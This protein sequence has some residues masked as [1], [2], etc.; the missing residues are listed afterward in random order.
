[1]TT[2]PN[3]KPWG[4]EKSA[5]KK[6][7][8]RKEKKGGGGGG[9]GGGER[10][11]WARRTERV[12]N[13]CPS[14][15]VPVA[16]FV[17]CVCAHAALPLVSPCAADTEAAAAAAEAQETVA[18]GG[19]VWVGSKGAESSEAEQTRPRDT[20]IVTLRKSANGAGPVCTARVRGNCTL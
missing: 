12:S 8:R 5:Q 7:R 14:H 1:L 3:R 18:A 15:P 9:G 16:H 20:A 6:K 10:E 2:G 4:R 19:L 17:L 11:T 13:K